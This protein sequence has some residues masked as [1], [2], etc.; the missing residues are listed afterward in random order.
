MITKWRGMVIS[1]GSRM[2]ESARFQRHRTGPGRLCAGNVGPTKRGRTGN[3]RNDDIGIPGAGLDRTAAPCGR[4]HRR[5]GCVAVRRQPTHRASVSRARRPYVFRNPRVRAAGPC[6]RLRRRSA[7]VSRR[8]VGIARF[9]DSEL[10]LTLVSQ[11]LRHQP[12]GG[13]QATHTRF[14]RRSA[15]CKAT[16]SGFWRRGSRTTMTMAARRV[17][18][19]QSAAASAIG[20]AK[21]PPSTRCR[22]TR[23]ES[24]SL[25]ARR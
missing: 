21:L 9:R 14:R 20:S 3:D 2:G 22:L 17:A 7:P 23:C 16:R 5:T 4:V 6:A 15:R 18:A 8:G 25:R 11:E 19:S 12:C 13:P 24:S 1:A 10:V